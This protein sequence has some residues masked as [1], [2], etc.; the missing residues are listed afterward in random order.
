MGTTMLGLV[1]AARE[2]G[3][4]AEG[5]EADLE[6][7]RDCID[8]TILHVVKEQKWS[9]FVVSYGYDSRKKLWNI[10]DPSMRHFTWITDEELSG[11]W[12][13]KKLLLLKDP[14]PNR[15]KGVLRTNKW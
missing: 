2:C 13:T 4:V 7:L 3:L 9:H 14:N 12:K 1:Q 10:G 8:L 5:Y 6:S 15:D 11:I